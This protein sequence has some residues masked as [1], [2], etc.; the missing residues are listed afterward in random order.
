MRLLALALLLSTAHAGEP[1]HWHLNSN[2]QFR[3]NRLG[4]GLLTYSGYRVPLYDSDSL[5]LSGAYAEA[6]VV[7]QLSPASFHPGLY[8]QIAPVTPL[9]FRFAARKLGYF[10]VFGTVVEY[11]D[12]TS[13]WSPEAL[14]ANEPKAQGSVGSAW[15]A[16]GQLRLKFGPVL[17][18]HEQSLLGLRMDS[19]DEGNFWYESVND[20]LVARHDR[21]H[22]MKATAAGLIQGTL[23]EEFLVLGA[24]WESYRAFESGSERQIAGVVGL[25]RHDADWW[26]KP[27]AALL[28]GVMLEDK[29]RQWEPYIGGQVGITLESG[30]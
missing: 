25:Y 17:V 15:E 18:L 14:D 29:Y 3:T 19:I 24:H 27:T 13:D 4:L 20:L 23:D 5:L 1:G 2:L 8:A 16:T 7:T 26:G 10:G 30:H 28:V 6:G 9:V 11:E 12:S 22:V 21:V